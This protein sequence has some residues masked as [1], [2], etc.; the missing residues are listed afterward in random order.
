MLVERDGL[1]RELA[2]EP[3]R[4]LDEHDVGTALDGR[5]GGGH[6]AEAAAAH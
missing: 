1:A 6:A 2:A 5:E 3:G 4:R